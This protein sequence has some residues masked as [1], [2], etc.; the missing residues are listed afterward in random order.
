M[1]H[2]V[3]SLQVLIEAEFKAMHSLYAQMHADNSKSTDELKKDVAEIKAQTTATNGRLMKAEVAIAV[4][5]FAVFTIG[6][7]LLLAAMQVLIGRFT[8][9]VL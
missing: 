7:A 8:T 6:G 2:D 9:G 5:K 1:D 4:L 3:K